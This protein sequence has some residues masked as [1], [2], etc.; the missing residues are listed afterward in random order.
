M[1]LNMIIYVECINNY[2]PVKILCK[3]HGEFYQTYNAHVN[4][5]C[6]CP[7]CATS[8]KSKIETEWLNSFN[9]PQEWRQTKLKLNGKI[10]KPDALDKENKIIYEFY[11]DLFHGHPDIYNPTDINPISKKSFGELYQKT[12][13][14]EEKL[15]AAGYTIISMWESDWNAIKKA[16]K[17]EESKAA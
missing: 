7:A 8:N 13:S 17:H 15:K 10:Y 6:G 2:T 14:R 3:K 1:N 11:G 12:I 4:S 9:I 5:G 16:Q